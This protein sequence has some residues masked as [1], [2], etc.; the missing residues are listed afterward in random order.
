[1]SDYDHA[2]HCARAEATWQARATWSTPLTDVYRYAMPWREAKRGVGGEARE[3][4]LYDMTAVTSTFRGGGRLA[5]NLFPSGQPVA[6]LAPGPL[7][8]LINENHQAANNQQPDPTFVK[9]SRELDFV[10]RQIDPFFHTGSWDRAKAEFCLELYASTA[11]LL[12]VAGPK[13]EPL[14][15]ICVPVMKCA[16][17]RDATGRYVALY[18]REK[19]TARQIR[20]AF[21]KGK[22]GENF[23]KIERDSPDKDDLELHQDYVPEGEGWRFVARVKGDEE[24]FVNVTT[25]TKP[26][27]ATGLFHVPGEPMA[28]GLAMLAMPTI[29]T[30]NKAQELILKAAA[31]QMLGIWGYRPGGTFN[32]DTAR[33]APGQM[34]ALGS[35]GGVMGADVT[36]LDVAGGKI[37]LGTLITNELRDQLRM[38]LHDDQ[39]PSGGL[40]PKSAAEITARMSQKNDAYV[41]AFSRLI[42][43]IIPDLIPRCLE[44]LHDHK[45]L[46][47]KLDIDQL[48]VA[49]NVVSPMV[50][51][52]KAQHYQHIVE[53]MQLLAMVHPLGPKAI[54]RFYKLDD[55]IP[56]MIVELGTNAKYVKDVLE[57]TQWDADQA[58]QATRAAATQAVLN[59]PDKFR[60]ALAP[61]ND[62]PAP[63]AA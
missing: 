4:E 52:M 58:K 39:I 45:L 50:R 34:W 3:I 24:P 54:E 28:R 17:E 46:A 13:R 20:M 48:L 63:A 7:A 44:I 12:P 31:I 5:E 35:T 30:L 53:T 9:L 27:V 18:I 55:L 26:F 42:H 10:S 11:V 47:T 29:K 40:T 16:F 6:E 37:D 57:L 56:E 60:D 1:M 32:P 33:I 41:G 15:F 22:F 38:I 59:K 25:R 62:Q 2:A 19:M 61:A 23:L 51:A 36:R 14:Q 43:E 8:K 21:P 49:V